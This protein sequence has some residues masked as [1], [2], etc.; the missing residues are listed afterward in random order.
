[1]RERPTLRPNEPGEAPE[2]VVARALAILEEETRAWTA[3]REQRLTPSG[4]AVRSGE[5]VGSDAGGSV[6]AP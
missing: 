1:M 3:V 4:E 5:A 6:S 2:E